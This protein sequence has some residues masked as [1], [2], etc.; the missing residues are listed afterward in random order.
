[1]TSGGV[2]AWNLRRAWVCPSS[3]AQ[4]RGASVAGS[5][6]AR[7]RRGIDFCRISGINKVDG[8]PE[9][10]IR[11]SR[12]IDVCADPHRS[13]DLPRR[14][15]NPCALFL[16]NEPSIAPRRLTLFSHG[17]GCGCK[18]A[19][20]V[21]EQILA[22]TALPV[23]AE[24]PARRDRDQRRR[25]GLSD[26]RRAGDRRDDGL[27]HA[28]RRRSVRLRRHRGDQ[29]DLRRLRDGR[30]AA[31][32]ARARRHAGRT[33]SRSETIRRILEGG[34]SVCARAGIP[35][36]GGHTIDSVEPIYGLVAIGLVDPRGLKRNAGARAGDTLILGKPLGVGIYS[37]ALKK[38]RLDDAGLHG[39]DRQH[40]AA[41]HA[42]HRARQARRR[43]RAHRRHRLRPAR[44]PARDRR[45]SGLGAGSTLRKSRCFRVRE[46]AREGIVTGASG[47][48][49][50]G[51]GDA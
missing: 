12:R 9:A 20:G 40:H 25:R 37:A 14:E 24:G 8:V 22:R 19:P 51:Y 23:R 7:P 30:P 13:H 17:G 4:G 31:V 1:M 39:D 18:I 42:R 21:L 6:A 3:D 34:E 48:N 49:W 45:A 10:R 26:Q 33:R 46:F 36:A 11:R 47:R 28:D 41:Q 35:I 5:R 27:L 38:G 50:T 2:V 29:R 16:M 15:G 32:R 44:P 43:A